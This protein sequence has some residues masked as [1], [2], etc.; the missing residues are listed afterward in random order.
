LLLGS[1]ALRATPAWAQTRPRVVL[2]AITEEDPLAARLTAELEAL[3]LDVSRAFAAASSCEGEGTDL[4]FHS[5]L[6]AAPVL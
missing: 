3:G 6:M 4:N 1:V 5:A 2:L